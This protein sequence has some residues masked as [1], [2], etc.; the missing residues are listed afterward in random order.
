MAKLPREEEIIRRA[1]Q[2]LAILPDAHRAG[3][4][5]DVAP[6]DDCAVIPCGKFDLLLTTDML[7]EN[8]HFMLPKAGS[9]KDSAE[10]ADAIKSAAFKSLSV[11]VSDIAACGGMPVGY[12]VSLGLPKKTSDSEVRAFN[13]GLAKAAKLYKIPVWG[14][15]LSAS[16]DWTISI[17]AIGAVPSGR[18]IARSGARPGDALVLSGWLGLA[19]AGLSVV[20]NE[21][22]AK[23]ARGGGAG[24]RSAGSSLPAAKFKKAIGAIIEPVAQVELGLYLSG[25]KFA[26]S[27]I[28]LSDSLA[29]SVRL[30]ASESGCGTTLDLSALVLHLEVAKFLKINGITSEKSKTQFLLDAA[31]DYSLLF[32]VPK[33]KLFGFLEAA[34]SDARIKKIPFNVIGQITAD[35]KL[36]VLIGGIKSPI[37]ESGFE[38]F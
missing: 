1:R 28:D 11:N 21:R 13:S 14:G 7:V 36:A 37:V 23:P 9:A 5:I 2:A 29:K 3:A 22:A 38:H 20:I 27:A 18:A 34:K 4:A 35:R 6:G 33:R 24:S 15:D 26:T 31:E 10:R 17:T 32:T 25:E 8:T 12:L 30:I 19:S 16:K